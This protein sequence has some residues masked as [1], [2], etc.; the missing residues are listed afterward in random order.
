MGVTPTYGFPYPAL[1]DP[2]N[3]PAQIQALAEAVEADLMVTDSNIATIN[4]TGLTYMRLLGGT[5]RTANSGAINTTET[6]F[7]TTGA[8]ALPASSWFAIRCTLNF[9]L[10]VA[11]ADFNMR[12]RD[13]NIAGTI[14]SERFLGVSNQAGVPCQFTFE[15]IYTTA[16]AETRTWVAT[17]QRATG[18][19]NLIAETDSRVGVY[20]LGASSLLAASNP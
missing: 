8:V 10:S 1:T 12:F 14:V 17:A 7:S 18:S 19:G 13:N 2:P 4:A 11:A 3:G 5:R 15:M 9:D 20:Y 6:V 16:G